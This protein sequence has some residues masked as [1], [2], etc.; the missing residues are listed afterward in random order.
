MGASPGAAGLHLCPH[1]TGGLL[2][3]ELLEPV[4]VG[5]PRALHLPGASVLVRRRLCNWLSEGSLCSKHGLK[6]LSRGVERAP[7]SPGVPFPCQTAWPWR[8]R[9]VVKAQCLPRPFSLEEPLVKFILPPPVVALLFSFASG[10]SVKQGRRKPRGGAPR[11]GLHRPPCAPVESFERAQVR[12]APC[13][14]AQGFHTPSA[15]HGC[16]WLCLG[17]ST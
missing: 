1:G 2:G 13:V 15:A 14:C 5:S 3:A 11:P 10:P 12:R 9:G 8:Q 17:F 16:S 6:P 4:P 7:G